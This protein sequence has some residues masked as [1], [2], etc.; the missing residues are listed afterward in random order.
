MTR[1]WWIGRGVGVALSFVL[2]AAAATGCAGRGNG[3]SQQPDAAERHLAAFDTLDFDVFSNQ[4]WD[5]LGETHEQDIIVTWQDARETRGPAKH[6]EDLKAMFV[7]APDTKVAEHPIR[8]GSGEWTAV[9]GIVTGTFSRP[10]PTPDG[11]AIPPT[12]KPF[13]I[14]MVTIGHW[15]ECG[16][17]NFRD[18]RVPT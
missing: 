1:G 17:P 13:K 2:V 15:R 4:K 18:C 7:Y 10:M 5:G 11:K 8:I 16:V 3:Q 12:G 9:T 14:T 6:I